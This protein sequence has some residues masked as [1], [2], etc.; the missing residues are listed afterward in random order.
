MNSYAHGTH[1]GYRKCRK[2]PEG[3]CTDCR[4]AI[5]EYMHRWRHGQSAAASRA[6]L[7]DAALGRALWRL[8]D[9]Y[10]GLFRALVQEEMSR[11]TATGEAA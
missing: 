8:A 9:M 4:A 11:D 3:S 10:P 7:K 2:R 1:A 5:N 6:R